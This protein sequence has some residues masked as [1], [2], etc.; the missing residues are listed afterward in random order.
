MAGL[1]FWDNA[2]SA[3]INPDSDPDDP[4]PIR[5]LEFWVKFNG[6]TASKYIFDARPSGGTEFLW[7]N[8]SSLLAFGTGTL[9]VNGVAAATG[10]FT[11]DPEKWYHILYVLPANVSTT[12]NLPA[13]GPRQVGMIKSYP[14]A[15]TATDAT[16]LYTGYRGYV[17]AALATEANPVSEA[18]TPFKLY[19]Y[20]W[21]ISPTG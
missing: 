14:F 7:A 13:A 9:Y 19:A 3:T 8:A 10:T 1:E 5:S 11:V 2:T 6:T 17:N 18:A 20:D 16:N 21:S 15:L 4:R 12:I